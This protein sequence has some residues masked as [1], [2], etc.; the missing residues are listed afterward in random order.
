[1]IY[2]GTVSKHITVSE[3][4]ETGNWPVE[5]LSAVSS[6][7]LGRVVIL[8]AITESEMAIPSDKE[9]DRSPQIDEQKGI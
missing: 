3:Q 2:H 1:M 7:S 4:S 8:V 6:T 9:V 5:A